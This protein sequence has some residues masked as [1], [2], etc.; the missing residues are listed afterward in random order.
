MKKT[1]AQQLKI[2]DFPFTIYDEDGG[3]L[4]YEDES[5]YWRK[6]QYFEDSDD[7]GH[8]LTKDSEGEKTEVM[9]DTESD[10]LHSVLP[11]CIKINGDTLHDMREDTADDLVLEYTQSDDTDKKLL[12]SL[13]DVFGI[14]P[15]ER[16]VVTWGT[17]GKNHDQPLKH[18]YLKDMT[19][20]HIVMILA[21]QRQLDRSA[22]QMAFIDELHFRFKNQEYSIIEK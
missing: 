2:N 19:N 7:Y 13:Y 5:G 10:G 4:Y 16:D 3:E 11:V 17:Y 21:T 20:N 9:F 22:K 6:T 14:I 12:R 1:I 15:E 18:V 8:V